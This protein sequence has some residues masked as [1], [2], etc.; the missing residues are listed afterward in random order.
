MGTVLQIGRIMSLSEENP[1]K[2][3]RHPI[4]PL[5]T[6]PKQKRR[7][8]MV[9]GENK[10]NERKTEN[11]QNPPRK[12]LPKLHSNLERQNTRT[13]HNHRHR[14]QRRLPHN[15]QPDNHNGRHRYNQTTRGEN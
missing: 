12:P 15:E 10:Q 4:P 11:P 8:K 1:H 7:R 3:H 2:N 6:I 13:K 5:E 14:K 9:G